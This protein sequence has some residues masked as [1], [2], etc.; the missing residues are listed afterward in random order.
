MKSGN[1]HFTTGADD[2]QQN[3]SWVGDHFISTAY[4]TDY[5]S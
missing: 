1:Y 2:F 4:N 5:G 3:Y